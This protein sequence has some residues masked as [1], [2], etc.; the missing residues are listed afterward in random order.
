[1]SR[2]RRVAVRPV[3]FARTTRERQRAHRLSSGVRSA[4]AEAERQG[5]IARRVNLTTASC[6][7]AASPWRSAWLRG[8]ERAAAAVPPC[9]T[10]NLQ[11]SLAFEQ[12]DIARR[13]QLSSD[14]NPHDPASRLYACW[15]EG[16]ASKVVG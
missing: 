2:P 5:E 12:G 8:W 6:P 4:Y 9:M 3:L 16:Y 14:V 11:E 13:M 10:G 7:Y 15:H 1:M